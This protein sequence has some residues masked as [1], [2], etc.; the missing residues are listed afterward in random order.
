MDVF[1]VFF[2]ARQIT[3][4]QRNS[5]KRRRDADGTKIKVT[6]RRPEALRVSGQASGTKSNVKSAKNSA[7]K[8]MASRL[9]PGFRA[10]LRHRPIDAPERLMEASA[11][12][13]KCARSAR[14][15]RWEPRAAL[16]RGEPR[17]SRSR[18]R[19]ADCSPENLRG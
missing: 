7:A 3:F 15:T 4:P 6:R 2:G 8:I 18:F 12:A 19:L 5:Q 17:L 11:S 1:G 10:C 9:A 13:E 14:R 16:E